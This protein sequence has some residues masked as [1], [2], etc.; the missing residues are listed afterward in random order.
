MKA[1]DHENYFKNII[2]P[3][4]SLLTY[5]HEMREFVKSNRL[6]VDSDKKIN[7]HH[8]SKT[9]EDEIPWEY[10]PLNEMDKTNE[11]SMRKSVE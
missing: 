4:Q 11:V 2:S 1:I 9:N 10:N 5:T 8:K 6:K 3:H 7:S